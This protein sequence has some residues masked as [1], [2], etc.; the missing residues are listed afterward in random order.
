VVLLHPLLLRAV[1][2]A[3]SIDAAIALE[4][5]FGLASHEQYTEQSDE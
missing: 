2:H 3:Q 4:R 5:V 1:Y